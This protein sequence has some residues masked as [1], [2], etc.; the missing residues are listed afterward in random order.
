MKTSDLNAS[1]KCKKRK[2]SVSKASDELSLSGDEVKKG[3]VAVVDT[4]AQ[5]TLLDEISHDTTNTKLSFYKPTREDV[6]NPGAGAA[7]MNKKSKR[8]VTPELVPD[9]DE[10]G[11][12]PLKPNYKKE[13]GDRSP[14]MTVGS[15]DLTVILPVKTNG[16]ISW[17]CLA[18]FPRTTFLNFFTK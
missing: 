2:R 13:R 10:D 11:D 1:F 8:V 7:K 16:N 9:S 15:L 6:S 17:S 18:I 5:E 3:T 4:P 14:S 12:C